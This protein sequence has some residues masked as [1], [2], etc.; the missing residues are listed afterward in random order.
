[1]SA[2]T[3]PYEPDPV[4]VVG[5]LTLYD[6]AGNIIT[7]GSIN[8]APFAAYVQGSAAV[9]AG[10]T[11]ATLYGYLP[12]NGV[13]PGSWSGEALT[14]SENYPNAVGAGEPGRLAACRWWG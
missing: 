5:G 11:K 4:N 9:R 1:M 8:D 7:T 6:A 3:P 14:A 12:Q 10:D 2:A 13:A